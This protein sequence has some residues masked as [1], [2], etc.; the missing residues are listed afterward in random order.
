M[1]PVSLFLE[2][3]AVNNMWEISGRTNKCQA[4][5]AGM[6]NYTVDYTNK[7]SVI[8]VSLAELSPSSF[9]HSRHD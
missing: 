7:A 4:G 1:T 9:P 6:F 5:M 3:I 2:D 8:W